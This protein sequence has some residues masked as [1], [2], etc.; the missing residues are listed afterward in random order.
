MEV[1]LMCILELLRYFADKS[2]ADLVMLFQIMLSNDLYAGQENLE[3]DQLENENRFC[4][5]ILK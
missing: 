1:V 2:H 3:G 5:K 4:R